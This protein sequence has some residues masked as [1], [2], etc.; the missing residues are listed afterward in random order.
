MSLRLVTPATAEIV[1]LAEAKAHLRIDFNDDDT[2]ITALAGSAQDWLSGE[3]NW[4]GRS[5]VE[6]GWELTL[7]RFPS[8]RICLPKPPLI[9]VS[10]VFYT[11]SDG[12]AEVEI[13]DFRELDVGVSEGGYI[14]PAKNTDWP[15]TDG[16]PGSVRVTF[17]AGYA[18]VPKSIKHAALLMIGHWYE[19]REAAS[20]TKIT[21]LPMAVDA[22]LYPYRN[23]R[24]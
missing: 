8:G 20:E 14:L 11:P 19:N 23:W 7:E 24:A 6:Q 1:T 5:V 17:A 10:G 9:S 15:E 2:Y 13:M 18:A 22:L 4:L 21:D 12:G 16:E 3:N